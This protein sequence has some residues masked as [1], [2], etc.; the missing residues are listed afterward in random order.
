MHHPTPFSLAK[1]KYTEQLEMKPQVF[2]AQVLRV[3]MATCHQN[4]AS[5]TKLAMSTYAEPPHNQPR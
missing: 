4:G 1:D 5:A 3:S 2:G